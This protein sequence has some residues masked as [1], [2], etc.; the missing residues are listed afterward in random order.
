MLLELLWD[1]VQQIYIHIVILTK[2]LIKLLFINKGYLF[3]P[4]L[5]DAE[6]VV[7]GW[8]LEIDGIWDILLGSNGTGTLGAN[9][10][11]DTT[12]TILGECCCSSSDSDEI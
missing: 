9:G 8:P 1:I 2:Y 7:R 11:D 4:G 5:L 6:E 12:A 3:F 10:V